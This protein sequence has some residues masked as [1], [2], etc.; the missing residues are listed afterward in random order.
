[1]F[2]VDEPYFPKK[3]LFEVNKPAMVQRY[4]TYDIQREVNKIYI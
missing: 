3:N 4:N 1:M 2:F